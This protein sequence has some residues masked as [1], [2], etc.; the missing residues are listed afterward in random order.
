M[1]A[2]PSRDS[3]DTSRLRGQRRRSGA[4]DEPHENPV[5]PPARLH[6]KPRAGELA[7]LLPP[8]HPARVCGAIDAAPARQAR[9]ASSPSATYALR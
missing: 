7:E 3:L 1:G 4:S 5:S 8:S 6:R 2:P 9:A